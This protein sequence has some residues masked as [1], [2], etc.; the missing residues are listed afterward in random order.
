MND[1]KALADRV[2][3]L[4][5]RTR[6]ALST[7]GVSRHGLAELREALIELAG[8]ASLFGPERFA[9][10]ADGKPRMYVLHAEPDD[11]ITLYVNICGAG[12]VSPPHD[13]A[14]WAVIA[15]VVGEERNTFYRLVSPTGPEAGAAGAHLETVGGKSVVAGEAIAL[16]PDDIHSIDTL[17]QD[18]VVTL[19]FYGRSLPAQ[20][21]R[22]AFPDSGQAAAYA[23]QPEIVAWQP[24]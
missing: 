17:Q 18:R 24:R 13:H 19:H 8:Q 12:V 15:G 5:A 23:P 14:T 2:E 22:R 4:M 10:A 16:M 21:D 1:D 20:T 7:K 3:D 11:S 6:R 9:P